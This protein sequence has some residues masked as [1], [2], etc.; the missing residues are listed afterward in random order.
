MYLVF[1]IFA[2]LMLFISAKAFAVLDTEYLPKDTRYKAE[3]T[4]PTQALGASVGEWHARHDQIAN[5]M[6][7]LAAQSDRVS[8]VE[9]GRTHENRPLYLLAFSSDK[10]QQNLAAIQAR[11]IQN[12]GQ[13]ADNNDPLIIWMGYSVHGDE[14][15]GS[16]A[17]LLIAYYLA[18]GESE[19]IDALLNDNI[20]LLDPSVNPDGLSRFA[21]W[22]N[23]H[24]G[25]NLVSDP[26][27]REHQQAWPSGRTNHYWFD[28]NRDWL[29]L[30]HPESRARIKQFHQW[31]P[32]V[33]TDFHEM[34]TNSTYFFQPGIA[35]RKNPWTPLKNVEL[36]AALGDFHAA[37]LDQTKQLYFTQESYDDFY[38]GKGSTYPDAHGSIGIL[39]EQASSRGHLQDSVNGI[40]KF[41]DTIQNQVTTSLSTFAGALANKQALLDYQ[42]EFAKQTKN[43]VKDDDF[44]GYILNEKFDQTRFSKM[45]Q[46]LSAHQIQFSPLSKDIVVD[47]QRFDTAN[48]MFVPLDQPQ[49]RLIRSLFSTRKSFEDNT[50]YDVSN[51]N[52]PLAFNIQYQAVKRQPKLDK[53][54]I[55]MS[56]VV[57]PELLPGAYAYAFSWKDYQAPKLLQRLLANNIKVKLAGEAFFAQTAQG[58]MSFSAGAVIVP[59][60]LEQPKNLLDIIDAQ[61][62]GLDITIHSV[63]SGLTRQ[64]IDLGSRKMLNIAQPKVLLVG[65]QGTSQYELGEVWHYLDKHVDMPVSITDLGQLGRFPLDSYTHMIWVEGTYKE[66]P[67]ETVDKIEDWLNKGGVLI[68][69]K[70]AANWFSDKKWLK[71]E[72]KSNSEITLAFETKGM[73]YKDQEALKAKQRI[74]GAVFETQLDISHPLAFGYTS[75]TLPMFRN[76]ALVMRQPDKPFISVASY[77]KSPLMAGYSADELQ[78]LIGGSAAIVSHN[79]GKGKVIG[80]ATNVNFRGVWYGTSRLM[81]NAIFMAGFINAPG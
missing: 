62:M 50:F 77:V 67:K 41:S 65:G 21:Q 58:S 16:N 51:W 54:P 78:Q 74:S 38:Y 46:I 79:F 59:I 23:M 2:F 13:S 14:P 35:S 17:A 3:I 11:H 72:F 56:T 73:T 28:L 31:R 49:Y 61:N 24:K 27:H 26:N 57:N 76:S 33:L 10:N 75:S 68:G 1:R 53:Q 15:S 66:V 34:G 4:T 7:L 44:V 48:S 47:G 6:Q 60:A 42:V 9:T 43:L 64:G 52:L 80:F 55:K 22:A 19:S 37:A 25:K 29:L 40:L 36:T 32:H 39:F 71:A 18:A 70:S 30:T 45:L 63:T 81:S 69:Q 12:L 8:L 5:Y 20:V